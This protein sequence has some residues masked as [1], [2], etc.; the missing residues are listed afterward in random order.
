MDELKRL[1]RKLEYAAEDA[2]GAAEKAATADIWSQLGEAG[3]WFGA[4]LLVLAVI[5]LL[6]IFSRSR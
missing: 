6:F 1:Q 2:T 5:F 3:L 4:F